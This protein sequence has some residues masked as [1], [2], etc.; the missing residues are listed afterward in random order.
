MSLYSD[1]DIH[2]NSML[3]MLGNVQMVSI[4]VIGNNEKEK[5]ISPPTFLLKIMFNKDN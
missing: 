5:N 1:G 3:N 2:L 4:A